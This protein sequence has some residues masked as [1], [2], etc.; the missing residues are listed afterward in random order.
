M[1]SRTRLDL[2][3]LFV[4]IAS[5]LHSSQP[6]TSGRTPIGATPPILQVDVFLGSSRHTSHH[7]DA[8][9]HCTD[10]YGRRDDL[11]SWWNA[12]LS[13]MT[14]P[15][16]PPPWHYFGDLAE[17]WRD[18][19]GHFLGSLL[20]RTCFSVTHDAHGN[21]FI[22]IFKICFILCNGCSFFPCIRSLSS[23]SIFIGP[24]SRVASATY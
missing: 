6:N 8:A 15:T 19:L 20:C 12:V 16:A 24:V 2:P 3:S 7:V 17:R 4:P 21:M 18:G 1:P 10:G 22:L 9:A 13:L 5:T 14:A 23:L 11:L